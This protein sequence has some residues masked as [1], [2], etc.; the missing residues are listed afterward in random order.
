MSARKDGPDWKPT[1]GGVLV[2]PS[3]KTE[4]VEPSFKVQ[5]FAPAPGWD[6]R[7]YSSITVMQKFYDVPVVKPRKR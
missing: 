4:R 2:P 5:G 3:A 1:P 6:G 7:G